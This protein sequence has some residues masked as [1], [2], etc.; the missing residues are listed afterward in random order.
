MNRVNEDFRVKYR[1]GMMK[2]WAVWLMTGV[3][4][5]LLS[6]CAHSITIGGQSYDPDTTAVSITDVTFRDYAQL[7]KLPKLSQLDLTALPLS[8]EEYENIV[9]Q[10]GEGVVIRW[11]VPLGGTRYP[12]TTEALHLSEDDLPQA[13]GVLPYFNRLQSVAID[14]SELSEDL[15]RVIETVREKNPDADIQCRCRFLGREIDN[16]TEKL[17]LNDTTVSDPDDI[18]RVVRAFPRIQ[19]LEMCNCGLSDEQ[20]GQLREDFPDVTFIWIIRFDRF[21]VRTDV[22]VFSTLGYKKYYDVT[23]ETFRPLFLYCTELRALDIGHHN[24]KDISDITHLKKL[25]VLI[26]TDNAIED[27]SPLAELPALCYA[28]L[29]N[30]QIEDASPLTRLEQIEDV[31]L[32]YNPDLKNASE[33]VKCKNLK[34]LCIYNSNLT[35]GEINTLKEHL[36]GK[37]RFIYTAFD[38]THEKR[39]RIKQAFFQWESVEEFD[40][41]SEKLFTLKRR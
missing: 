20:M 27:I 25:Q 35:S 9:S 3:C 32:S 18:R 41:N 40:Y 14:D 33:L 39:K 2:R 23:E 34:R 7:K 24:V 10:V 15:C 19:T 36:P 26:L 37:C 6:G 11:N 29:I 13:V 31:N 16:A 38:A 17:N 22:K 21:A 1:H 12:D 30:N 4:L 8:P 28:E 5:C